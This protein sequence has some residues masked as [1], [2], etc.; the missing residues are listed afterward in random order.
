MTVPW[1]EISIDGCRIWPLGGKIRQ[2]SLNIVSGL[3]IDGCMHPLPQI[4][5]CSCTLRTHTNQGPVYILCS[6]TSNAIQ[7][8]YKIVQMAMAIATTQHRMSKNF[9]L[10]I[11]G[12]FLKDFLCLT[13]KKI[14]NT[15]EVILL[16]QV[17]RSFYNFRKTK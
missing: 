2:K 14:F 6:Q 9:L 15:N 8:A 3:K 16:S 11:L 13:D 1:L 7:T 5:G 12:C 4:D 10:V 17:T